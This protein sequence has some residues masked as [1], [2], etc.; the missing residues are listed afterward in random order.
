MPISHP[1]ASDP[2]ARSLSIPVL[3]VALVIFFLSGFAALLYQVIW[4]RLLVLFSGA[5]VHSVTIIVA[6]FMVG[7]GI[8]SLAGGRLA[9][10]LGARRSLWAF[11]IAEFAIGC[12]GLTSKW[13][14]YDGLYTHL[15]HL[16]ESRVLG[17]MVLFASLL[18]PTFFMGVS[19]PLL[20]RAITPRLALTGRVI[21]ALYGWNALGA[22]AGAF[23]G[24]WIL[25]PRFGL[26]ES[27]YIAAAVSLLCAA[28]AGVLGL[29]AHAGTDVAPARA[30]SEPEAAPSSGPFSFAGWA[31]AAGLSGFIALGFEIAAFRLLGV[32]LKSTAFTFGTLLGIYLSGLGLGAALASRRVG[33][34]RRPGVTFLTLQCGAALYIAVSTIVLVSVLGAGHPVKLVRYLGTYDPVDVQATVGLLQRTG[35]AE[36]LA[37]FWDFLFLY[38]GIPALLVGPPIFLMGASFPYLQRASHQTLGL[39]GARL[40]TLL[41]SNIAGSALGALLTGWVL[42]PLVGTAATL[43]ALVGLSACFAWPLAAT[44][45]SSSRRA[46]ALATLTVAAGLGTAIT[47]M[48]AAGT[49]WARLHSTTPP[50]LLYA[51]DGAGVSVLKTEGGSGQVGVYVNGLG[52]SWIPYGGIHTALGLLPVLLHPNP[53]AVLVIGLGS[54]ATAFAAASRADVQQLVLVE[55]IGAQRDTLE[56]LTRVQ[57]YPALTQ[58]LTDP[59]ITHRVGDGRAYIMR[60]GRQFDVIEADALRPGSAYSGTLYSREYFDLLLRHLAPGGLAVTWAPTPRVRRTFASVFPHVASFEDILVGSRTAIADDHDL[61]RTRA[62]AM[63]P[64]F[65]LA[66]LDVEALV[67]RYLAARRVSVPGEPRRFDDLNTDTFPRDEFA[68]P[69]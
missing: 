43:R 37:P 46:S 3:P 39:L 17:A 15:P 55:I 8:G 30:A 65:E 14:Y 20:A 49:L 58:L 19:L 7:L 4:Q 38:L 2:S 53:E 33:R 31:L 54:G 44:L 28:L 48:P 10:R 12:F 24:T 63:R 41:A 26:E 51:E 47:L 57:P 68:R 50:Q 59:R 5:D 69:F 25:M 22:A 35:E 18:W 27:L 62:A 9:D 13:L 1:T 60:S 61:M 21:G 45:W 29:R 40:G 6:A 66:G 36:T 16:A 23:A 42:L 52:Q 64:Y 32:L 56:Q 67:A 11:A 34:S